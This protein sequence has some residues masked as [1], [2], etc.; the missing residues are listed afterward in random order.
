MDWLFEFFVYLLRGKD[1]IDLQ[2][3]VGQSGFVRQ[4]VHKHLKH[5]IEYELVSREVV[6]YGRGSQNPIQAFCARL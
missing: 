4:K 6:K 3:I 5:L 2:D 1:G